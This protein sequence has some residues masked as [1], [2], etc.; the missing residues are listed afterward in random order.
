[1]E[2]PTHLFTVNQG[3]GWEGRPTVVCWAYAPGSPLLEASIFSG[4]QEEGL[5]CW[6]RCQMVKETEGE[7]VVS[8]GDRVHYRK[9]AGL[10]LSVKT[11]LKRDCVKGHLQPPT[12]LPALQ[13]PVTPSLT[14]LQASARP[15]PSPGPS[16]LPPS[17]T[18]RAP[19]LSVP[20]SQ[21]H[22]C[23]SLCPEP[24][25]Q[26]L[27]TPCLPAWP[28]VFQWL[29][30]L[31]LWLH[32]PL[33]HLHSSQGAFSATPEGS[34]TWKRGLSLPAPTSSFLKSQKYAPAPK[35]RQGRTLRETPPDGPATAG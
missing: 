34:S 23:P 15:L 9:V 33:V 7:A 20:Q 27:A 5:C 4:K 17:R 29:R 31:S 1:M 30:R 32:I 12:P 24:Q 16:Q 35:E 10:T 3:L 2:A 21:L 8:S 11:C 22:S 13:S 18:H 6:G 26:G 19:P 14:S 25:L 28:K